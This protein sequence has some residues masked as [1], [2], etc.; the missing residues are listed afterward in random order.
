LKFY[1]YEQLDLSLGRVA[2][3][4]AAATAAALTASSVALGDVLGQAMLAALVVIG[5][6]TFYAVMSMPRRITDRQRVAQS[7]EAVLLTAGGFA[8]LNVTGSR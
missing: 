1:S 2:V 8:C 6:L 7:R 3:V 5:A 4:G